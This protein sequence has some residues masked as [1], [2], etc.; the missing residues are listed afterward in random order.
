MHAHILRCAEADIRADHDDV[1]VGEVE[2]LGNAVHHRVTQ[3][4]NGVDGAKA[5][6]VDQI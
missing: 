3:R 1:A 5:D 4:D 2:H 6:A